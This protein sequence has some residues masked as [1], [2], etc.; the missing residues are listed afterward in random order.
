VVEQRSNNGY[1]KIGLATGPWNNNINKTKVFR[2]RLFSRALQ[3]L[4]QIKIKKL[5]L[6]KLPDSGHL[7]E[8]QGPSQFHED[9]LHGGVQQ[10]GMGRRLMGVGVVRQK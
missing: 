9:D 6:V 1:H 10:A 8:S 4:Y 7:A 3:Y 5:N 2:I